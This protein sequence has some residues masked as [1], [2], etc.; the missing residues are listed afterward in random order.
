MP[1]DVS[2]LRKHRGLEIAATK[3]LV[4]DGDTWL[5]PSEVGVGR[6]AVTGQATRCTCPD[7][8]LREE[9]CKHIF[10]VQYVMRRDEHPAEV[11]TA[12]ARVSYAQKWSLYNLAQTTEKET[13]CRLLRDL[14]ST[15]PDPEPKAT[16]RPRLPLADMLFSAAF[17]IYSTVSG[18]R[19]QTD[20]REAAAKGLIAK[21]PHYNSIFNVMESEELT[22]I[23]YGL[24]EATSL[25]LCEV[26]QDFAADSTGFGSSAHFRYYSVR[27]E[28]VRTRKAWVKTHAMIGVKTN[29]IAAVV[30]DHGDGSDSRQFPSLIEATA[31]NFTIRE[32]SADKAYLSKANL[33]LVESK[34]GAA[35]MPMKAGTKPD[36]RSPA[37]NK[38][39]HLFAYN[40]DE[41]SEH[42]HK[43]SNV[44]ATFSAVK[45]VFGDSVR[46]RTPVA[47]IN[48]VLLKLICH[49]IR[50]LIHE[51]HELGVNPDLVGSANRLPSMA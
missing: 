42:Y 7:F 45:R 30:V 43:R 50:V 9:P 8:E 17:K 14:V 5:V 46:S 23:L 49:N 29:V 10:A 51:M 40:R 28:G 19:F 33:E 3:K 12:S 22:P 6:Y 24:L 2:G 16:G 1:T 11:R 39:Y 34:G 41:F 38:L 26:E 21:A 32:V 25:P 15:V 47:Q 37:W 20:L 31:K 13:F 36:K 35:Y 18:R 27:Y 44:E 4:R 48:E